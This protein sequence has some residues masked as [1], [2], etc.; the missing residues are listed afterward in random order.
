MENKRLNL[1]ERR[2]YKYKKV[3]NLIINRIISKKH[4]IIAQ[5]LEN[6]KPKTRK[7]QKNSKNQ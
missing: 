5:K 2:T 7:T 6:K 3:V 4:E 1:K